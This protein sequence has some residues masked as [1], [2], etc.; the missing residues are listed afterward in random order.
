[1]DDDSDF[2]ERNFYEKRKRPCILS[3]DTDSV[4]QLLYAYHQG[5]GFACLFLSKLTFVLTVLFC[6]MLST[7]VL[8]CVDWDALG[9]QQSGDKVSFRDAMYPSCNPPGGRSHIM[10]LLFVSSFAGWIALVARSCIELKRFAAIRH[11]WSGVLGLS[12]DVQWVSWQEVIDR[13]H[14]RVDSNTDSFYIESC[15]MRWDNYLIALLYDDPLDLNGFHSGTVFTRV[16]EFYLKSSIQ[17]ALFFDGALIKDVLFIRERPEFV[18][19]LKRSFLWHAILGL[20]FSPLVCFALTIYFIYRYVGEF[21]KHPEALGLHTFTHIAKWKLRDFNEL[22]HVYAARL[23]RAHPKVVDFLH[24]F[25]SQELLVV[26]KFLSFTFGGILLVMVGMSFY[27]ADILISLLVIEKPLIFYIGVFT[28]LYYFVSGLGSDEPLVYEPETKFAEL[29][30][31]LRF[32]HCTLPV[33]NDLPLKDRYHCIQKLFRYR[34]F[35]FLLEIFSVLYGPILLLVWRRDK[36][37]KIISF[38]R[39]NSVHVDKLGVIC[40]YALFN[41]NRNH[42]QTRSPK[43]KNPVIPA[44][45]H[46]SPL[47]QK[48]SASL[49]QFHSTHPSWQ[50]DKAFRRALLTPQE[51]RLELGI[52]SESDCDTASS[53]TARPLFSGRD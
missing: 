16:L 43:G 15:I 41:T 9:R 2:D 34:W 38:F 5:K 24:Q 31:I 19:R 52:E 32:S 35:V 36:C 1:M 25:S 4:F 51:H 3:K 42:H 6:I 27:D 21:H 44:E 8:T 14:E 46:A 47:E 28:T 40:S 10:N 11:G 30:D 50:P 18:R 12:S 26:I 7:F 17:W 45:A 23:N 48:M 20:A 13:Y 53:D 29:D 37:F 33:W 49:F 39:E 22:P